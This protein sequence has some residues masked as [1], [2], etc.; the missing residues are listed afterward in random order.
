[1][2]QSTPDAAEDGGTRADKKKKKRQEARRDMH[3]HRYTQE[4][5]QEKH[6]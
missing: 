1:M 6:R 2:R 5:K 4:S 3:T